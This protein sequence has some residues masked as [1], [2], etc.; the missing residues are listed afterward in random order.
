[1]TRTQILNPQLQKQ[2]VPYY[3]A[4]QIKKQFQ[5]PQFVTDH[6]FPSLESKQHDICLFK[7]NQLFCYAGCLFIETTVIFLFRTFPKLPNGTHSIFGIHKCKQCLLDRL[8]MTVPR[9]ET[10]GINKI[11][12]LVE[13]TKNNLVTKLIKKCPF[14]VVQ[15]GDTV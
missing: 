3:E 14:G 7:R 4:G 12:F 6:L 5:N 13:I 8:P 1:M 15:N 10:Q 9:V 11:E 2:L